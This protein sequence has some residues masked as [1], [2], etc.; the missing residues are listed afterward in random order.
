VR[1]VR[2]PMDAM[3]AAVPDCMSLESL[4]RKGV[5]IIAMVMAIIATMATLRALTTVA[6]ASII[7]M[8]MAYVATVVSMAAIASVI[9]A[10]AAL[11]LP[12][13]VFIATEALWL[14]Y[15]N[16]SVTLMCGDNTSEKC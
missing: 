3:M 6:V 12:G 1:V 14:V 10:V 7:S 8:I 16:P 9:V 4:D 13:I 15:I 5:E 11:L 2:R